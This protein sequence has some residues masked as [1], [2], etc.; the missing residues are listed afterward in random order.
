VDVGRFLVVVLDTC[1]VGAYDP[2]MKIPRTALL[3]VGI[4]LWLPV[5][6]ILTSLAGCETGSTGLLRPVDSGIEHSLTNTVVQVVAGAQ[7]ALPA[8]YSTAIE[9]AGAA[10]LALL[11]AWQG[12][13]HSKVKQLGA[14]NSPSDQTKSS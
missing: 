9:A 3:V 12:L 5:F 13:T 1:A 11:A 7:Q 6:V 10:V 4:S 14:A 2:G 8:P